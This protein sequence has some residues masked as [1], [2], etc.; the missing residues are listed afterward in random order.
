[1]GNILWYFWVLIFT[2]FEASVKIAHD[3]KSE[4]TTLKYLSEVEDVSLILPLPK[5]IEFITGFEEADIQIV[6]YSLT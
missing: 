3:G 1:M 2:S 5:Y 4:N 6:N